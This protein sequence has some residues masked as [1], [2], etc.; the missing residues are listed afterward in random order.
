MAMAANLNGV[1]LTHE[2]LQ[3]QQ[4]FVSILTS[5]VYIHVQQKG[6]HDN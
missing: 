2:A 6:Q 1:V 5:F 3:A 4:Q